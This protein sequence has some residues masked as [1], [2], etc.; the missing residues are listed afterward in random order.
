MT[1]PGGCSLLRAASVFGEVFWAEGVAALLGGADRA[2]IMRDR[3]AK[4][5]ERELVARRTDSRFPDQDEYAF[6]HTLLR[7]GAL[8]LAHGRGPGARAPARGRVA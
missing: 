8:C 6:R 4:L 5:V 2:L 1:K 7:E 3:L